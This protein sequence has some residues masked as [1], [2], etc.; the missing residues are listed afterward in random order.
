MVGGLKTE[1]NEFIGLVYRLSGVRAQGLKLWGI[2][3]YRSRLY[4][5]AYD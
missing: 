2:R 4:N 3:R 5:G 1:Y